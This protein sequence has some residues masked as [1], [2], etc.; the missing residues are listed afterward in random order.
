[1]TIV[2]TTVSE[3]DAYG[4]GGGGLVSS[5]SLTVTGSTFAG[6]RALLHGGTLPPTTGGP[7]FGGAM[8][9][10][11]GG[12]ATLEAVSFTQNQ[13]GKSG[14]A[15]YHDRNA[16]LAITG[17]TFTGNT[18]TGFFGGAI[19][20][21]GQLTVAGSTLIG[22]ST[23]QN[24]GALSTTV[25]A[26]TLT[27]STLSGNHAGTSGGA[28]YHFGGGSGTLSIAGCSL[29]GNDADAFGGALQ[30]EGPTTVT[31]GAITGNHAAQ[32]GGGIYNGSAA[33]L[34][35]DG[36]AIQANESEGGNGG[37]VWNDG[38]LH[39]TGVTIEGN[40]ALAP[41]A[42]IAGGVGNQLGTLT[43]TRSTVHGNT[44]RAAGGL[45]NFNG[46]T[47]SLVDSAVTGN[48]ATGAFGGGIQ[49]QASLAL[50]DVTVSGNAAT[51]SGAGV[52]NGH[53]GVATI[54]HATLADNTSAVGEALFNFS[55]TATLRNTLLADRCDNQGT[56]HSQGGNIESPGNTC[57]LNHASDRRN[58]ADPEIGPLASNG[59]PS[60]THALMDGSPAIDAALVSHCPL[61]DQRGAA[62]PQGAGC[63]VGA[64]EV[65]E[66]PGA[67][68]GVAVLAALVTLS[69]RQRSATIVKC[70]TLRCSIDHS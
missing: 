66:P 6:N 10:I 24:G 45:F 41:G 15:I 13:A 49:N 36:V 55:A 59:G 32:T 57:S 31:G 39:A 11:A 46:G 62:R 67:A 52:F 18:A 40:Q 58:V 33:S 56:L 37:G 43:L 7:G 17:S 34:T 26:A 47:L 1:M 70:R 4:E 22:N 61:T 63:D 35:L 19:L 27:S 12:N 5:G 21:E 2:D 9:L 60:Q 51:T 8:L 30:N 50:L 64:F 25:G 48:T 53:G 38:V 65:P 14:G 28:V 44:A 69:W 20:N 23:G 42:G 54:T 16:T 29:S 3:N 68:A